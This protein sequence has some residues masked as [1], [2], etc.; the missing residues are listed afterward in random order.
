MN[1]ADHAIRAAQSPA[2]IVADGDAVSYGG[3]YARSRRVAALLHGAGLR[4]GDGVALVLPNRPEFLEITWGCQLSGLYYSAVNTHFTP[5]D[6]AYVVEDS[7]AR[8]VFIDASMADLGSRIL[9]ANPGVDVH[10]AVGGSLSGWRPYEEAL[11]AAG[12]APRHACAVRPDHVRADAQA[13]GRG[14]RL[15]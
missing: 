12:D 15:L 10:V 6:V 1:I 5:D 7:E 3:L 2:L 13:A 4:R 14:P 8:A 11:G 9:D